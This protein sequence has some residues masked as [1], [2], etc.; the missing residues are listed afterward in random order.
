M[1]LDESTGRWLSVGPLR[2]L[3]EQ[4]ACWKRAGELQLAVVRD[5]EAVHALADACPH[6]GASLASGR[7]AAGRLRC[8]AHGLEFDLQT[9]RMGATA[10]AVPCFRTSVREGTVWVFV[11][12]EQAA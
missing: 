6:Q 3:P 4:R 5:G 2:E 10:L 7:V 11:P 9:G 12:D 8:P 1:S